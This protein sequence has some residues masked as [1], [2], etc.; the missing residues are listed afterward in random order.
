VLILLLLFVFFNIYRESSDCYVFRLESTCNGKKDMYNYVCYWDS[1][2]KQCF[3]YNNCSVISSNEEI[4]GLKSCDNAYERFGIGCYWH[5]DYCDFSKYYS[6][7]SGHNIYTDISDGYDSCLEDS[8]CFWNGY[9][10]EG[11]IFLFFSC[12]FVLFSCFFYF[13][14]FSF[15]FFF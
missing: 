11:F 7:C 4:D 9:N 15:I 5:D 6:G 8:F 3:A 2:S 10:I 1:R 12:F 14:F 13:L